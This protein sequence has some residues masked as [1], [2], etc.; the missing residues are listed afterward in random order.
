MASATSSPYQIHISP[1]NTGLL[2]LK[3][4]EEASKKV[5]ELLQKDLEVSSLFVMTEAHT[6]AINRNT[7]SSSTKKV[8]ITTYVETNPTLS[9]PYIER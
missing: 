8:F 5:S 6:H 3:Q 2:G 7:M 4:T 1:N 9:L